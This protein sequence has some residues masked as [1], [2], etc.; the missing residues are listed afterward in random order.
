MNAA[1]IE[2]AGDDGD[3]DMFAEVPTAGPLV[4][5]L[6]AMEAE[7]EAGAAGGGE[8]EEEDDDEARSKATGCLCC[9]GRVPSPLLSGLASRFQLG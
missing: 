7:A 4:S 3:T 1:L 5:N 6:D 8:E 9:L 2:G